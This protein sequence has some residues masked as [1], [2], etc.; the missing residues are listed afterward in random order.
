MAASG[1]DAEV[2]QGAATLASID[3]RLGRIENMLGKLD[4]LASQVP[5]LLAMAGDIA[6]EQAQ[7]D[8]RFDERLQAMAAL[9]ERATRPEALK[10]LMS[11]LDLLEGVPGLVAMLGDILDD[12]SRDLE[13][14][15]I[16][17][18]AATENGMALARD[19]IQLLSYP[20]A[21]A[22][23]ENGVLSRGALRGVN[24]LAASIAGVD[25]AAID[26]VGPIGAL[27][28]LSDRD[29]QYALG[30][31]VSVG[32]ALGRQVRTSPTDS[33]RR[34]PASTP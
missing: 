3:A 5:G 16:D 18:N 20:E 19:L 15:G 32:K 28:K 8:G 30:F 13:R 9:V 4:G 2:G 12:T 10:Q 27:F 22:L 17:L 25:E 21:R 7:Q 33:D 31:A 11:L 29:L 6:D 1:M 14:S 24:R 26:P 34:I 23:L